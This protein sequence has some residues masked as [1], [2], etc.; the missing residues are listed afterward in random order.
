M[1]KFK[2]LSMAVSKKDNIYIE[3]THTEY[4]TSVTV[5]GFTVGYTDISQYIQKT[6]TKGRHALTELHS[7]RNLPTHMKK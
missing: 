6:V 1:N 4:S 5:L 3:G 7:F 2:I